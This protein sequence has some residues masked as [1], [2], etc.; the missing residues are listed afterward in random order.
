MRHAFASMMV[1]GGASLPIV[2][3]IL[4]HTQATTTQRYAH[5]EANPARKAAEEAAA[6]IAQ[7][8]KAGPQG[9][10][11]PFPAPEGRRGVVVLS[12][13]DNTI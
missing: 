4:G 9:R 7:A 10:D 8:M 2:G 11:H 13:I 5:L 3:K 6:K 12:D 1:N